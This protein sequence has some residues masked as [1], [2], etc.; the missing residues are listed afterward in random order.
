MGLEWFEE[1]KSSKSP[2]IA[3]EALQKTVER[4][5]RIYGR[6]CMADTEDIVALGKYAHQLVSSL[7]DLQ[8]LVMVL[9]EIIIACDREGAF[10]AEALSLY[11][12]FVRQIREQ[13]GESDLFNANRSA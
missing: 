12:E 3:I 11:T 1:Q 2:L 6:T 9:S 10:N 7:N 8:S 13:A 5:N 4:S